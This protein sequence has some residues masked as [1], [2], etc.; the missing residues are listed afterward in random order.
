MDS[1]LKKTVKYFSSLD[2]FF[3]IMGNKLLWFALPA[4]FHLLHVSK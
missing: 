2:I 1:K 3:L 4:K